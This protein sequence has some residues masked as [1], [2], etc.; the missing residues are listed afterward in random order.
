MSPVTPVAN[1]Q[2]LV[3]LTTATMGSPYAHVNAD[4]S[5]ICFTGSDEATPQDYWIESWNNAGTSKIW[6]EVKT[7]GAST[8]YMYYGNSSASST[9]NG[10]A[11][12]DFFDDFSGDLS[13]WERQSISDVYPK[14]ESGYLR[15]GGGTSGSPYGWTCLGSR[16]TYTG[17]QN[18]AVEFRYRVASNAICEVS[19][20]GNYASNTGYKG[21][22]DQR[23]GEG[24]SFLKPPYRVGVWG[25]ITGR[26]GDIPSVNVW[27]RGTITASG[28]TFNLY[29]DGVL[30][31]SA[32]DTDYSGPGQISL[33]NHYGSYTDYDWVAVRKFTS[34][35]PNATVGSEERFPLDISNAPL[36]GKDFGTVSKNSSYW[37]HGSIP[38]TTFPLYD[39]ECFFTVTNNS[40]APVN[41][42]IRA[43]NF[44]SSGVGWT[45]AS[46]PGVNIV[47][48]KAGKSGDLTE[49]AMVILTITDKSFITGLGASQSKKWELK[50]ETG[51][52]TD[53]AQKTST[54]TLT[55][56]YP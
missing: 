54:I 35:E 56:T 39:D 12:F 52:F 24:Q 1:Y 8:I 11:T 51:T 14:I 4:G 30:K 17:F 18:N 21:R 34:S 43:T 20:R 9:S 19:F 31:R 50:L 26:D 33:Q 41:I 16:P 46:S 55:A 47:V 45:L 10:T 42:L 36:A 5:D 49:G 44:T 37:S 6:V 22:S 3:T 27:Y 32:S 48:L 29:R 23:S 25:F 7:S 53:A 40:S 28:S 15:C 2:V 13:K 38:P